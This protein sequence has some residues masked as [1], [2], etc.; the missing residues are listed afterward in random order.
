M[1][2]TTLW[3]LM[4]TPEV[5][6]PACGST[7]IQM[8][9]WVIAN[10]GEVMDDT[11]HYSWCDDCEETKENGELSSVAQVTGVNAAGELEWEAY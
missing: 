11:G 3:D 7:T 1:R 2:K 8:Q 6:C 4:P 5:C 9:L 10:T